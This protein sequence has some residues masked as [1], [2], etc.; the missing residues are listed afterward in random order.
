MRIALT[1]PTTSPWV[2][3]GG[4]RFFR[5]LAFHLSGRG[6]DVEII[7]A[8]PGPTQVTQD[9]GVTIICHRRL[10]HPA[11][12]RAGIWEF[13]TFFFRAL[14]SLLLREHYDIVMSLTFMDT[15]A[16]TLTRRITGTPCVFWFNSLPPRVQYFRSASL[17]GAVLRRA[18]RDVDHIIA[19]SRYVQDYIEERWA[20]DSTDIP[21]PVDIDTF[22]LSRER[23]R[24]PDHPIILCTAA[25]D[26]ERKGGAL[27]MRAFNEVKRLRP[28]AVLQLAGRLTLGRQRELMALVAPEL[29]PDVHFLGDRSGDLHE[30]YGRATVS[31]LPS[32]CEAFGMVVLESMAT[33]TPVVGTR[34]GALPETIAN[35]RV[36]RLFDPGTP[37][38]AAADNLDGLVKALLEG[39]N[40]GARPE[41][42]DSCRTHA[43]AYS[44]DTLGRRYEALF[45]RIVSEHAAGRRLQA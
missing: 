27:L 3:R 7:S 18:V 6:H 32:L 14:Q 16:A 39:L 1:T 4:E 35:D 10:W 12:G 2:Q 25:L 42:A 44:W 17:K 13:H 45:E 11:M 23:E 22:R 24:E 15:Y 34:D 21:I 40:L 29:R 30:V 37:G 5:E 8:K 36:G 41:T 43:E 28:K 26:D 9:D 31:V 19:L 33:G 20:R 38:L